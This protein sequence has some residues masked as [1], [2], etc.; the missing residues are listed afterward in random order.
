M[1]H[2][3]GHG[4]RM[5]ALQEASPEGSLRDRAHR[6]GCR[7]CE[8]TRILGRLSCVALSFLVLGGG[9]LQSRADARAAYL[10]GAAAQGV[11]DYELAMEK[12]KEALSLNPAYL[13]PMVGPGGVLPPA[14]GVRR[15]V[16]GTRPWRAPTTANNPDLAVLEGRIRIGQGDVPAARAL[17][18]SA[19]SHQQP[20]NVEARLGMAEA[21]IAEGRTRNA[22]GR[23]TRRP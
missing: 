17:F 7:R 10:A 21:D 2:G 6:G 20:N 5:L 19:C 1:D 8:Q 3:R 16:R 11:E 4:G 22:L 14:G 18:A 15:G 9:T 23:S 13:E 12:Y